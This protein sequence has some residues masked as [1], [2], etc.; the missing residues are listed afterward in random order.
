MKLIIQI[1]RKQR[2]I[3]HL[4]TFICRSYYSFLCYKSDS[5]TFVVILQ[6]CQAKN[7]I[8]IFNYLV[9]I[10]R[11][12]QQTFCLINVFLNNSSIT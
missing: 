5:Q 2:I 7:N 11:L 8:S 10:K 6:I 1:H 3:K 12:W 9:R 4:Q